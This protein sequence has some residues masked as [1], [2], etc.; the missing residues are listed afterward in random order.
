MC[1]SQL[2]YGNFVVYDCYVFPQNTEYDDEDS[3][4]GDERSVR[5]R[6][7]AMNSLMF[8]RTMKKMGKY[9]SCPKCKMM[10]ERVSGCDMMH[11]SQC[12]TMFCWSCGK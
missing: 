10:V 12:K 11:C 2:R 3:G 5:K 4:D 1:I 9:Q 7:V 8:I 6:G